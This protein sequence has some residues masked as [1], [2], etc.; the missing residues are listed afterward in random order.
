MALLTILLIVYFFGA[1]I[2]IGVSDPPEG[3]E[4]H[5]KF[6]TFMFVILWPMMVW[7]RLGHMLVQYFDREVRHQRKMDEIKRQAER[8]RAI[9]EANKLLDQ[10][11]ENDVVL[12]EINEMEREIKRA[13]K[14][15]KS[16]WEMQ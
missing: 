1:G 15:S 5:D 12:D 14:K 3:Y 7:G 9:N 4:W 16:F 2:A 8:A 13:Q 11:I 6:N 10:C